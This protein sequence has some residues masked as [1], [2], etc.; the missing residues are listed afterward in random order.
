[1]IKLETI[2]LILILT[3][4]HT[5]ALASYTRTE[6][7]NVPAQRNTTA[8][9]QTQTNQGSSPVGHNPNRYREYINSL[10]K[11]YKVAHKRTTSNLPKSRS[12]PSA[13]VLT[14]GN[15]QT[16]T[17]IMPYN[18]WQSRN[19]RP[20]LKPKLDHR[21]HVNQIK[22]ILSQSSSVGFSN[23]LKQISSALEANQTLSSR[24]AQKLS[25][26]SKQASS[27]QSSMTL[28]LI[29]EDYR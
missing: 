7:Q 10:G 24:E 23:D 6:A 11:Q 3:F 1:M 4:Y 29:S 2:I 17:T 18:Q 25:E 22:S 14:S 15:A 19:Q 13:K 28:F 9:S 26:L 8:S 27:D 16:Q 20:D 21:S 5:P 12:Y